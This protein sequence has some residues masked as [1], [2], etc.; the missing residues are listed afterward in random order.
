MNVPESCIPLLKEHRTHLQGDFVESYIQGL[1]DTYQSF[2]PYLPNE[3][4]ILDIG[5]GMGGIDVL[6]DQHYG[7]A[8]I[9]LLDKQG[10]SPRLTQDFTRPPTLSRTI[11]ALIW[12]WK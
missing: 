10:I 2:K 4:V 12:H 11:T 9:T 5:C 7:G 8:E 1:Y 3:G 6:L